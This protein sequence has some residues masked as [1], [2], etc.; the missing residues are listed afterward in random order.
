MSADPPRPGM[1]V[2][3]ALSLMASI[4]TPVSFVGA[5][6]WSVAET[7]GAI[8]ENTRR[9]GVLEA[10]REPGRE[11]LGQINDRLA[12]IETKLEV[13]LPKVITR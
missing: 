9:I 10:E 2:R 13:A 1:T 11:K 7:R 8:S 4:I 6:V 12:R 3:D 5:M